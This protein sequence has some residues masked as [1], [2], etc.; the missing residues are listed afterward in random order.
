MTE[1]IIVI[2]KNCILPYIK[3]A[4]RTAHGFIQKYQRKPT[5]QR[6]CR[7]DQLAEIRRSLSHDVYHKHWQQD[8]KY[9]KD[10]IF[11]LTKQLISREMSASS[12]E[13]EFYSADP[14]SVQKDRGIHIQVFQAEL[15]QKSEN[16]LH[17]MPF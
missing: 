1:R 9:H 5:F 8:H 4:D 11:Q 15:R 14:G 10:Y 17:N 7:T 3:P 16:Q 2:N 13:T 6:T 12:L